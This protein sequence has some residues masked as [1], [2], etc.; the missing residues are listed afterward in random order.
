L[1]LEPARKDGF[2]F[3]KHIDKTFTV[4]F[5][6]FEGYINYWIMFEQLRLFYAYNAPNEYFNPMR[7]S[8]LDGVGFEFIA[9]E[10]DKI[11]FTGLSELNL[12]FSS[13]TPEFQT[14]DATFHYN[15]F[16]VK[17]DIR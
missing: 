4:T 7:L 16:D 17:K 10:F 11:L 5:K 14:F 9:F 6:L 2:D 1:I 8:F 15:Y 13:T 3:D 12:D